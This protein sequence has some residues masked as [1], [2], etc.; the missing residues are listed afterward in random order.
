M[1]LFK[2][3]GLQHPFPGRMM[4]L[5]RLGFVELDG[6]TIKTDR[7]RLYRFLRQIYEVEDISKEM[8]KINLRR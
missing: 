3:Y 2:L 1:F 5:F 4:R 6:E 7:L 8:I